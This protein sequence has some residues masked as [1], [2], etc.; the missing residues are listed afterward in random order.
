[1]S[2]VQ[3]RFSAE[4]RRLQILEVAKSL[5]SKKGYEGTT[6]REIAHAA[7]VNEAIIFRH[8]P[9]KEELYWAVIDSS[10]RT[11]DARGQL[12]ERLRSGGDVRDVF[13]ELAVDILN[14]RSRDQSLTRLLF[15]SALENHELSHRFFDHYVAR[16]Y[17]TL[18]TYISEQIAAG[19]FR[20]V[21]PVIAAR[22]FLGM[23][24][25]YSLVDTLFG[26]ARYQKY[27]HRVVAEELSSLWLNG[28]L[29]DPGA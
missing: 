29:K 28:M 11:S 24:V 27:D 4:D 13:R 19:K 8:F 23:V 21:D 5:F 14:R 10:C 7:K 2:S 17:D 1:M 26:G 9:T 16:F 6:T 18:A 3:Q 25:Y 20:D 12:L 22:G 15:F